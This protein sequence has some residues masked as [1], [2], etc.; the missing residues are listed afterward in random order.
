METN[1][2]KKPVSIITKIVL[3]IIVLSTIITIYLTIKL[4]VAGHTFR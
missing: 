1:K 4:F 2:P 3:A